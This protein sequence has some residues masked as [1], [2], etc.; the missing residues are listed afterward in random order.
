MASVPKF[1]IATSR[2]SMLRTCRRGRG[3]TDRNIIFGQVRIAARVV[4]LE[5]R[6]PTPNPEIELPSRTLIEIAR[7]IELLTKSQQVF[8]QRV[9]IYGR[10]IGK[11]CRR[12]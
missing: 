1:Q 12:R 8:F 3:R 2:V 4:R 7:L 10:R 6:P 5:P 11:W 9:K